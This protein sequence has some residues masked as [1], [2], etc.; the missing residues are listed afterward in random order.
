[1]LCYHLIT[2]SL[3][4]TLSW[5]TFVPLPLTGADL[6]APKHL[7]KSSTFM[8][9]ITQLEEAIEQAMNASSTGQKFASNASFAVDVF[10]IYEDQPYLKKF[11]SGFQN[12]S[13]GTSSIDDDTIFRLGSISKLYTIYLSLIADGESHWNNPI[14]NYIPELAAYMNLHSSGQTTWNFTAMTLG[15]LAGQTSGLPRDSLSGED[16]DAT[17]ASS[18]NISLS[19]IKSLP[20]N[21][22]DVGCSN[23]VHAPCNRTGFIQNLFASSPV[24]PVGYQPAYSNI[25]YGLFALAMENITG[26]SF[27]DLFDTNLVKGFN[28]TSTFYHPP[29][30]VPGLNALIPVDAATSGFNDSINN[31]IPAGG[32]F[33][34]LAD[35]RKLSRAM[36]S[37][38]KLSTA[39]TNRWIKPRAFTGNLLQTVGDP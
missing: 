20:T 32:Y 2:S 7:S 37:S 30:V 13:E 8:A 22:T 11:Y 31:A 21:I 38:S 1:M 12:A 39:T 26:M 18:Y 10:S 25:A 29:K 17:I 3:L 19:A 34:S 4:A 6:P 5:A 27:E 23:A 33:S 9:A 35:M 28:L 16:F 24:F 36:L 14:T 15:D